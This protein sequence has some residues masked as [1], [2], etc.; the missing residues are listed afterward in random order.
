MAAKEI[1]SSSAALEI[2]EWHEGQH[3]VDS[4]A[5]KINIVCAHR[6][7]FKSSFAVNKAIMHLASGR[8]MG[9]YASTMVPIRDNWTQL[10][11]VVAKYPGSA[12]WFN[13][14]DHT[15]QIPGKGKCFFYSLEVPDNA[16]GPSYPLVICEE[17]GMWDEGVYESIV[18]PIASKVDGTVW[19]FGTPNTR[20]PN[21][22]FWSM[23]NQAKDF[24]DH[25]ASWVIPARGADIINEKLV[26]G[27]S[28]MTRYANPMA[29]FKSDEIMQMKYSMSLRKRKFEIEYLCHFLSDEGGQ[30]E[31]VD[32]VCTV[33][34]VEVN[35]RYF[36]EGYE[37]AERRSNGWFQMG[38]DVAMMND[39]TVIS[40]MDRSTNSQ[41]YFHRFCPGNMK[42]WDRVYSAIQEAM[43]LFPGV[44]N[45]DCTGVGATLQTEMPQRNC[46]ITPVIFGAKNKAPI[47][48]HLS[49]MIA[50]SHLRLFNLQV[51]KF[52]LKSM[53]RKQMANHVHIAAAGD[54]HDDIPTSLALMVKDV[55]PV[56]RIVGIDSSIGNLLALPN[57][58]VWRDEL[59]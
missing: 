3:L 45:V 46:H 23:I 38:V 41:V 29:P 28:D 9:W 27:V 4:E 37:R 6:G 19:M 52:E 7:W 49:S 11:R 13:K 59:W 47:L 57:K 35:G 26:C 31:N 22:F 55:R 39:F 1:G 40:V 51:I 34:A 2:P 43:T 16:R 42:H 12:D 33:K 30:F 24:P 14:S 56:E 48:D 20:N 18:E 36:A 25:M 5:R 50:E 32:A 17:A 54:A 15:F 10:Q 21:N 58:S 8:D 53:E 44:C